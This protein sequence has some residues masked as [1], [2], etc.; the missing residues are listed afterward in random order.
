V[1][2]AAVETLTYLASLTLSGLLPRMCIL[3]TRVR[4]G[5]GVQEGAVGT[6][7]IPGFTHPV[8]DL[9]LEDVL[10][11]T[12]HSIG[13]ASKCVLAPSLEMSRAFLFCFLS[14]NGVGRQGERECEGGK[15]EGGKSD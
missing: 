8:K 2:D 4:S 11:M 14:Q 1:Q 15:R 12:Q 5:F 6:L 10:E 13:R 9:Y 7:N 3:I